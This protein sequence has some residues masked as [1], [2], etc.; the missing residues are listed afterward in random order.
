M[1]SLWDRSDI[2]KR[3]KAR[4]GGE[5]AAAGPFYA[6]PA[7]ASL[8]AGLSSPVI[9]L[10]RWLESASDRLVETRA[11]SRA[12]TARLRSL[13]GAVVD[14]RMSPAR[15]P[16]QAAAGCQL[17]EPWQG[18]LCRLPP[19]SWAKAG[20]RGGMAGYRRWRQGRG[21]AAGPIG[22]ESPWSGSCKRPRAVGRAP[23]GQRTGPSMLFIRER[24]PRP[25]PVCA[26]KD[27]PGICGEG[28]SALASGGEVSRPVHVGGAGSLQ[29]IVEGV[30]RPGGPLYVQRRVRR[31]LSV[32]QPVPRG[33]VYDRLWRGG[34]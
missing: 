27:A 24:N 1:S 12:S 9:G 21:S 23:A 34:L 29:S 30:A 3:S 13:I 33:D 4:A 22:G 20:G 11:L 6:D 19:R 26:R 18:R 32:A 31:A 5:C 15:A 25:S 17:R 7:C 8:P 10:R 28:R 16:G 2:L 14:N